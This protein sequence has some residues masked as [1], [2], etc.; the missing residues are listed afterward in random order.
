MAERSGTR[1]IGRRA[2][3]GTLVKKSHVKKDPRTTVSEA[4]KKSRLGKKQ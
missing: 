4:I 1:K 3:A 2:I